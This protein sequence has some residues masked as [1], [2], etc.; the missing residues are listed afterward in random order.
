[1]WFDVDGPTPTPAY[2]RTELHHGHAFDG[3]AVLHQ[4]DTTV[5][6]PPDWHAHVDPWQ[7]VWIE[8]R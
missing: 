1:V 2:A 4:Y 8:R 5:V 3:P 7:N 6:V